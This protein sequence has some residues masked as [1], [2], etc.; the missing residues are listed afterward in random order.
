M[1]NIYTLCK[2]ITIFVVLLFSSIAV[3]RAPSTVVESALIVRADSSAD[4]VPLFQSAL[5]T[6]RPKDVSS[7]QLTANQGH[8][9][10]FN[11]ADLSSPRDFVLYLDNAQIDEVEYLSFDKNFVLLN[12]ELHQHGAYFD[13]I[14]PHM[15]LKAS[16]KQSW[17][18]LYLQHNQSISVDIK[19]TTKQAFHNVIKQ[20]LFTLSAIAVLLLVG[21]AISCAFYFLSRQIKFVYL[22]LYLSCVLIGMLVSKGIFINPAIPAS[23]AMKISGSSFIAALAF[24]CMFFMRSSYGQRKIILGK[25]RLPIVLFAIYVVSVIGSLLPLEFAIYILV[26]GLVAATIILCFLYKQ[27][28]ETQPSYSESYSLAWFLII[29]QAIVWIM[30]LI[31]P[32][33]LYLLNDILIVFNTCVFI[34]AVLIQDRSRILQYNH[35]LLHD[36]ETDLPNKKLLLKCLKAKVKLTQAHSL[37]LF[38]PAVLLDARANFGYD[39]ANEQIKITMLKLAHLLSSMSAVK[40]ESTDLK[41]HYIARL[42]DSTYAFVA[43]G[44]L[45]LSQIEQFVCVTTALFAEGINHDSNHFVNKVD[46][47]VAN[48]PLHA[49]GGELLI[50]RGLQAMSVKPLHGERWHMYNAQN[51][52]MSQHRLEVASALQEAIE[53]DQLSL[54]F[55]PQICLISGKVHGAEALLRW[56]HP[57]LGHVPPDEFIPIAE[58]SGIIFELTE[59]VVEQALAYQ[60]EMIAIYPEHIISINIS[61]KDLLRK[62]LPVLFLTLLNEYQL[63]AA[64]VMLELTESATLSDGVNIKTALND[65][66]LIGLKIAIDDFGTGYSSLAYLSKMGFDEIKIDKQFVMNIEYSKNDQTICRATC[67]IAKS[68]GS[69]VV[70]EGI[71]DVQ[72]L[73]RLKDYGC[74]IG[75]GYYFSRPLAFNDYL[76]WL[77]EHLQTTA[78]VD[79]YHMN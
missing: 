8:W 40:I 49:S 44:K 16:S 72:S 34:G 25:I 2:I 27:W 66:R 68:L 9:L 71:E 41:S 31:L 26:A 63:S 51:S 38:R 11:V 62:E 10:L 48:Y 78:A 1:A 67:D 4:I 21:M 33:S 53:K 79:V 58:S 35:S 55:Q 24:S 64:N 15:I 57:T 54:F 70:A 65:Y 61:A 20:H 36:D 74:E 28:K 59:W 60:K 17:V 19:F 18:A 56:H 76:S 23:L 5:E 43:S 47:G 46:I 69:Y 50:Q 7:F 6:S 13:K 45:E 3:A 77:E 14:I 52:S 32:Y 12:S 42:D 73:Q 22:F 30:T 29:S 75:Q 37:V 39:H